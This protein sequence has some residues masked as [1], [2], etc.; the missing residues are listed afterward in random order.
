MELN[1]L[2]RRRVAHTRTYVS[3]P[4]EKYF[5]KCV[6]LHIAALK[7]DLSAA[8][9]LLDRDPSLITTP[10]TD[11]GETAFHIAAAEGHVH[12]VKPLLETMAISDIQTAN[13][14]GAT[15]LTFSAAAGHVGMAKMIISKL[16]TLPTFTGPGSSNGVTPLFMT[17]LMGHGDIGDYLFAYSGFESWSQ[18][19]QIDLLIASIESGLYDL[20]MKVVNANKNLAFLADDKG[21][22]PLA[23]LARNPSAFVRQG[24]VRGFQSV[25][26]K[27]VG[28]MKLW[29]K[30]NKKMGEAC[31]A[32]TLFDLLWECTITHQDIEAGQLYDFNTCSLVFIATK[33]GNYHFLVLLISKDPVFLYKIDSSRHSIFHIAV[34]YRH[35]DIFNLIYEMMG[36]KDLMV[37][38]TEE[39][40]RNNMLHLAGILAPQQQLNNIPGAALK[41]QHEVLWYKE[42]EKHVQPLY[43]NMKNLA[44]QTPHE[45]F[46]EQHG[47]LMKEGEKELKHTAKSFMLVTMLITTVVFA[48][49]FTVPGGYDSITGDPVLGH[50][51]KAFVIFPI[52]EAAATLSSL[53]SMLMFL[54]ILT[55][56]YAERDFVTTLPFWLVSGVM[57][58]FVSIVA[59]VGAL[60]SSILFYEHELVAE[61]V[62][63]LLFGSV[64]ILFIGL[65]Y[66]L[67]VGI[68]RCTYGGRWLFGS[69][70]CLF[71]VN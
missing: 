58:L 17:A 43:R 16:P 34:K 59:M 51:T 10:I 23:V 14:K 4:R 32:Y 28:L 56:T 47:P 37:T 31:D 13:N 49:A 54:S 68:L 45:L 42:V 21:N 52:C 22:T 62:L 60:C 20:A 30:P 41:M 25:A 11:H 55:S 48:A 33:C 66:G 36:M 24:E 15:A 71:K 9:Q 69:N 18:K 29:S 8:E 44:G 50:R 1:V 57:A 64:P 40:T 5:E 53:M 19:Q 39:D 26:T 67:L 12:F 3:L 46:L 35:V 6:P 61:I 27:V 70:N 65:K 38:Y 7:G 63:M 2:Q